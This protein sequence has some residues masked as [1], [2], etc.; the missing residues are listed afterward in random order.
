MHVLKTKRLRAYYR[1]VNA[2]V[3]RISLD[4]WR[5]YTRMNMLGNRTRGYYRKVNAAG[6]RTSLDH[7]REYTRVHTY[8]GTDHAVITV[9]KALLGFR[10][11]NHRAAVILGNS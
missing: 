8:R 2:A 5:E 11:L 9:R 3:F 1:E 6:F 10:S 4:H 7:W